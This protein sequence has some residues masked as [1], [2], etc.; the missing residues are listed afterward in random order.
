[1]RRLEI[2]VTAE[3]AKN[4][5]RQTPGGVRHQRKSES[6]AKTNSAATP[7]ALMKKRCRRCATCGA[8]SRHK[9]AAAALICRKVSPNFF[10]ASRAVG[11]P[12]SAAE[13]A[14]VSPAVS[15]PPAAGGEGGRDT[16]AI[17]PGAGSAATAA[18]S[19]AD[20]VAASVFTGAP[21]F[22][23]AGAGVGDAGLAGCSFSGAFS[24]DAV[25]EA[26]RGATAAS[27]KVLA[28][29]ARAMLRS[30]AALR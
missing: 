14:D 25:P 15:A 2:S 27:P 18:S 24:G 28:S 8:S 5:P 3:S 17:C 23:S 4:A 1:M 6:A 29:R 20:G 9:S 21:A 16:G 26:V 19:S 30:A 22:S 7:A 12:V 10:T 13:V 11:S